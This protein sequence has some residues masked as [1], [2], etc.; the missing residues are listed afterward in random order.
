V[1]DAR[2][3]YAFRFNPVKQDMA[4]ILH[5]A[6]ARPNVITCAAQLRHI[7]EL[8]ATG[9]ETVNVNDSLLLT[10][11]VESVGRDPQQVCLTHARKAIR[12]HWLDSSCDLAEKIAV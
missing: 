8:P 4:T 12:S 5:T 11:C 7:H 1:E 3:Q 9:F 6:Q 2:Y 10:P